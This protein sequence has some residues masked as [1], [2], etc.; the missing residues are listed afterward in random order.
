MANVNHSTLT[1]PYLHEP[2]GV[3]AAASGSVYVSD[4]AGSGDWED[5]RRSVFTL[6]FKDIS[7]A[8]DLYIPVPFGG[9]V[10]RLTSVLEG[11]I[12]GSD[13]VITVKDSADASMGTITVTQSGSA[14]GDIDFLNPS[15]NNTIT[16]N[17]YILLQTNGG[18]TSHV[19]CMVS[20]VVEHV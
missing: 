9:T 17:D 1:D 7:S 11:A 10:S 8:E 15:S 4:G 13:L 2:K 12:S 6:H 5:H 16:D 18:P 20:V 3:A 19:D 14:A